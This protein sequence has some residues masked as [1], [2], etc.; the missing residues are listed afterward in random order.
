[1]STHDIALVKE[2]RMYPYFATAELAHAD[3][4]RLLALRVATAG[5]AFVGT[6]LT[7]SGIAAPSAALAIAGGLL[8]A[9]AGLVLAATFFAKGLSSDK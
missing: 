9:T 6:L 5:F 7:L 4:D 3:I 2:K 1:M 8:V